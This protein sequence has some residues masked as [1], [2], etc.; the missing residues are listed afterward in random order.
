MGGE[1]HVGQDLIDAAKGLKADDDSGYFQMKA[2][3]QVCMA[4]GHTGEDE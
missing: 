4:H 1:F 3:L 2:A